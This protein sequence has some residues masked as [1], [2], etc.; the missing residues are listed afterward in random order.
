MLSRG[1]TSLAGTVV[2]NQRARPATLDEQTGHQMFVAKQDL[3]DVASGGRHPP[4]A[5]HQRPHG[6]RAI[7]KFF[8]RDQFRPPAQSTHWARVGSSRN[9]A[10]AI[11]SP[12]VPHQP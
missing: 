12:H 7:V 3:M 4:T 8:E 11:G 10:S 9:R 1:R 6:G 2:S 5:Q